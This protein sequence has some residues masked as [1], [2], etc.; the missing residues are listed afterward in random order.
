MSEA[1]KKRVMR[2]GL[3]KAHKNNRKKVAQYSK[4]G[5]LIKV[6]DSLQQAEKETGIKY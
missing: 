4:E 2:D 3:E 5:A 1:A 6:F